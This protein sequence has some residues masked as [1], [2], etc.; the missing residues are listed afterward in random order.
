MSVR[1]PVSPKAASHVSSGDTGGA[2]GGPSATAVHEH[3]R[4]ARSAPADRSRDGST[5]RRERH[6]LDT[7]SAAES[8]AVDRRPSRGIRR[9]DSR[10]A[11]W[12][13]ARTRPCSCTAVGK[14]QNVVVVEPHHDMHD[15]RVERAGGRGDRLAAADPHVAV[16]LPSF[17]LVSLVEVVDELV[18]RARRRRAGSGSDRAAWR[19]GASRCRRQ[20]AHPRPGPAA[21]HCSTRSRSSVRP[22]TVTRTAMPSA[23]DRR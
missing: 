22:L 9:A 5:L 14:R 20:R 16:D 1:R 6:E 7:R 3:E 21:V 12:P 23:T 11:P 18:P 13:P 10:T 19:S 8:S 2:S 4:N 15:D 17:A